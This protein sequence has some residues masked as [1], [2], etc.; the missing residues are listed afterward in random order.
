ML[1]LQHFLTVTRDFE[2][3]GFKKARLGFTAQVAAR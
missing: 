3:L 1:E 2:R